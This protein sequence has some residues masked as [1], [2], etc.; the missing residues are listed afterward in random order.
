MQ[1]VSLVGATQIDFRRSLLRFARSPNDLA[2]AMSDKREV[3]YAWGNMA[4]P[5]QS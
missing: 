1:F 5:K 4:G 2:T 3:I